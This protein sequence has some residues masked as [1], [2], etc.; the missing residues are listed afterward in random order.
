MAV[1]GI[2]VRD[3]S[4]ITMTVLP[5]PGATALPITATYTKAY[6]EEQADSTR[7]PH[8]GERV[9]AV[10]QLLQPGA[11]GG[12]RVGQSACGSA[13]HDAGHAPAARR[14]PRVGAHYRKCRDQRASG[15]TLRRAQSAASSGWADNLDVDG[16]VRW[17]AIGLGFVPQS[18]MM[19][20]SFMYV[21]NV[22]TLVRPA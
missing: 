11:A 4:N 17:A 12:E 15:R 6:L 8:G 3:L 10:R 2:V 7:Q 21:G 9:W 13:L 1:G 14:L 20:D 16:H 18:V 22:S 19:W 5:R